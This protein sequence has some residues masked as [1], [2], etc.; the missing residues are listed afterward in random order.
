VE[1]L[2]WQDD[3]DISPDE[4]EGMVMLRQT[5]KGPGFT[6][7]QE[8]DTVTIRYRIRTAANPDHN[9]WEETTAVVD[10]LNICRGLE[11]GVMAMTPGSVGTLTVHPT[12]AFGDQGS[13]KFHVAPGEWVHIDLEVLRMEE[14]PVSTCRRSDKNVG[15]DDWLWIFFVFFFACEETIQSADRGANQARARTESMGKR[16]VPDSGL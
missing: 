8:L 9:P 11:V 2:E 14:C 15:I 6:A 4:R 16:E 13:E 3:Q 10:E 7:A 5:I 12:Y 1:L